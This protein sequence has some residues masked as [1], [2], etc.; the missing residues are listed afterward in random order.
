[1]DDESTSTHA[2]SLALNPQAHST[3]GAYFRSK[4]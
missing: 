4:D 2:P 1:M 3:F